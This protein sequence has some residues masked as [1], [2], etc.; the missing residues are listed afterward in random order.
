MIGKLGMICLLE[1][2]ALQFIRCNI[3]YKTSSNGVAAEEILDLQ[4]K[5]INI[6][7][8]TDYFEIITLNNIDHLTD[9]TTLST[10]T[11]K[12][13]LFDYYSVIE[14]YDK[15]NKINMRGL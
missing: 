3:I 9:L 15:Y 4:D 10:A 8:L 2:H 12:G 14:N 7:Q 13:W 1:V 11:M 6:Q 5:I